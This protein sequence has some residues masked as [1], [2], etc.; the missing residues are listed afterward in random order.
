MTATDSALG[1]GV[2]RWARFGLE[3]GVLVWISLAEGFGVSNISRACL[4]LWGPHVDKVCFELWL[5][6]M[7]MVGLDMVS[8][9][10]GVQRCVCL[11]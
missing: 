5:P 11:T 9:R 1:F 4:E 2:L 7:D 10:L 6:Y 3:L 8:L